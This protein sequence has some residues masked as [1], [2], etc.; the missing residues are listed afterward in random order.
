VKPEGERPALRIRRLGEGLVNRIAAGEVVERP[1]SVVKELAENA[2]DAGASAIDVV[3]H[4]GGR[5]LIR[6][7]DDGIGMSA[8][9]LDLAVERHATSK[10]ADDDLVRI[11]TLGF[12]GEALPSIGSVSRLRIVSR[13][14]GGE[15]AHEIRVEA[16]R[17]SPVR[18]A[19]HAR[20][21]EIEVR[22]LFHAVPARLKFLKSERGETAEAADVVRRLA[23]AWPSVA[24]SFA[25]SSGQLFSWTA[26]DRARRVE[27]AMGAEFMADAVAV[28]ARRGPFT[29]SG[30][31]SPPTVSRA[32]A[33][34]QY[35]F[36]NGR[37]VRDRLIAG[38]VRGAYAGLMAAGRHPSL[39]LFLDCPPE[40]VDVN[41]HPA[42]TEVRFRDSGFV[43]GL[44]VGAI[45]EALAAAAPRTSAPMAASTL[46]A[47]R[48]LA[49]SALRQSFAA[50]APLGIDGAGAQSGLAETQA[51][52]EAFPVAARVDEALPPVPDHPLGVARAQ[53]HAT[54]IVAETRA[55]LILVD[56]HAAHER[57]TLERLKAER[58]AEGIARQPLLVPEVVD[59]DP[60][61]VER[62]LADAPL[63]ADAGLVI[64]GFGPGAVL[65]REVP[66]RLAGG[67]I[68]AMLRD[69]AADSEALEPGGSLARRLERVLST[70]A[71]HGS[72]RSGRP[73]RAEEMN[74]LLREMERTPNAGQCN[75]GRPTF[76][77]LKL[78]D[79]ERLFGR[80]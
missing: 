79:I 77:E 43:R 52:F 78:A 49:P 71:C 44:I 75:H 10:L 7:S 42:K 45:R 70:M 62:L 28:E 12:R 31:V 23:L 35:A 80:R 60:V 16:G 76:V 2:I 17:K 13:P 8:D 69:L 48:T 30:L 21:T 53:L 50:Q 20:G 5:T 25:G 47:F 15:A 26:G 1:A 22:D 27:A 41:V 18:P 33:T 74:A 63:L 40:E 73:L 46:A 37:P 58:A 67:A 14:R 51:A 4:G 36:V 64:E 57:L 19:G 55:G 65:V 56:A 38:A 61:S 29:L 66:A 11:E 24:F 68:A 6:V 34:H 72:V 9:E 32:Q 59:L 39:V 3:F 54:W